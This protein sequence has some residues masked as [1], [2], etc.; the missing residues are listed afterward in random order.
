M[1]GRRRRPRRAAACRVA[2]VA[3]YRHAQQRLRGRRHRS[4]SCSQARRRAVMEARGGRG[5]LGH[6][7][8]H[9]QRSGRPHRPA[10]HG[11]PA[12]STAERHS[13]RQNRHFCQDL[14]RHCAFVRTATLRTRRLLGQ[15]P[16]RIYITAARHIYHDLSRRR[17]SVWTS[18][19]RTRRLLG[20]QPRGTGI[21]AIG[22]IHCD[23]GRRLAHVRASPLR[24]RRL[25]G[26]QRRWRNDD[27]TAIEGEN[28]LALRRA[29]ET[30]TCRQSPPAAVLAG[31]RCGGRRQQVR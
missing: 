16:H 26:Q 7:A 1:P 11:L 28:L 29:S 14:S 24:T 10:R 31:Q 2:V 3:R 30:P 23:L 18:P 4:G 6:P 27:S 21:A 12:S 15:Q 9:R 22:H 19:L 5:P 13:S 20:Q 25:L 8:D 17:A